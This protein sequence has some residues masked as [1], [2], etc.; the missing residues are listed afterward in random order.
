MSRCLPLALVAAV[1]ALAPLWAQEA[2]L[3]PIYRAPDQV[4][5]DIVDAPPTPDA[6]LGPKR[7]HMLWEMQE[8]M[9]RYVKNR[10]AEPRATSEGS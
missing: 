8:W 4:L 7:L 10:P 3:D 5:V 9:E 2:T 6:R 1:V